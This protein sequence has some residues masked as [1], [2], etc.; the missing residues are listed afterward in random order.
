MIDLSDG[1]STDLNHLA[2]ESG[3][4]AEVEAERLPRAGTLEQALNGGEDYELLFTV[5]A[6]KAA[7]LPARVGG[8]PL[9]RIGRIVK[10]RSVWLVQ[11]D[12]R[13]Q[14]LPPSGWQHRGS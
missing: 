8:V 14:K 7:Q 9:T 6:G 4:G 5:P 3:V 13:R 1:L 12:G 2:E 10:G 11:H